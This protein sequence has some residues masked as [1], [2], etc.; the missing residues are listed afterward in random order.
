MKV[1]STLIVPVA[2]VGAVCP[3]VAAAQSGDGQTSHVPIE[4]AATLSAHYPAVTVMSCCELRTPP[5]F[6]TLDERLP[7]L[8]IGAS[9]RVYW[10]PRLSAGATIAWNRPS[11]REYAYPAPTSPP[12]TPPPFTPFAVI[13][14]STERTEWILSIEQQI[15]LVRGRRWR[16]FLGGAFIVEHVAEHYDETKV[17]FTEPMSTS[18][19]MQDRE[20][21][22]RA[23]AVV[24][25][26]KIDLA[27]DVFVE[28]GG[29]VRTYLSEN[30]LSRS[31]LAWRAGVGVRF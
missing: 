19:T 15:D 27:T 5:R 18:V 11:R 14:R 21:T 23:A 6:T 28:V 4:I 16:P 30:V 2:L 10:K 7:V 31:T 22:Q 8:A 20:E 26:V 25:G 17:V 3:I 12:P 13:A 24:G 29:V 9:G 1:S